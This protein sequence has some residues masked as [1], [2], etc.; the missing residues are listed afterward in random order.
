MLICSLNL[1]HG[2]DSPDP[3]IEYYIYPKYL[4]QS[5]ICLGVR[6]QFTQQF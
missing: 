2:A 5:G 1:L 4:A 3:L 6:V